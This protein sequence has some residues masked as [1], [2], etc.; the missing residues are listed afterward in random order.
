MIHY[1][2]KP[3]LLLDFSDQ[4]RSLLYT[5]IRMRITGQLDKERFVTAAANIAHASSQEL[6]SDVL[7]LDSFFDRLS[8]IAASL[9]DLLNS[10]G[11]HDLEFGSWY[12]KALECME[13]PHENVL[14]YL[15]IL[16][17]LGK[18]RHDVNKE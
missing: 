14:T 9:F 7:G 18:L 12:K 10:P 1:E 13:D 2:D 15:F 17:L 3:G 6:V 5:A 11:D 16:S 4:Y 8:G